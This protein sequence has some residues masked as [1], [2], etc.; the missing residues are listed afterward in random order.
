MTQTRGRR[1]K[2]EGG[3]HQVTKNGR[4]VW[5][6][7]VY[8]PDGSEKTATAIKKTDAA[9]LLK[10]LRNK[11]LSV[12]APTD[13]TVVSYLDWWLDQQW[14]KVG[15]GQLDE[16]TVSDYA[17]SLGY[18]KERFP[19]V[20]L[21]DLTSADVYELLRHLAKRG[22]TRKIKNGY[23]VE[24]L[25]RRT[26]TRVRSHLAMALRTARTLGKIPV[27]VA[28]DVEIPATVD[29]TPQR[30]LTPAQAKLLLEEAEG[31]DT[32]V[33]AFLLTGFAAGLRPGENLG[34]KWQYLDWDEATLEIEKTLQRKKRHVRDGEVIPERLVIGGVKRGINASRRIMVLPPQV[35][36][37]LR[38][39]QVEQK[40]QQLRAGARWK[41]RHGLIFTS[42]V[43]TPISS[44]NMARRINIITKRL[45]LG[46]WSLSELT[47]H[48]FA[49]HV[50]G[51]LQPQVMEKAMGH[52]VGSSERKQYIHRDKPVV[53]EHLEPMARILGE[54]LGN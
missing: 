18:V 39:W 53:T 41:N 35:L 8:L 50:E 51:E 16:G 46:H 7:T 1:A 29:P 12:E 49:T 45:N 15:T 4:L 11:W 47:R 54:I 44:N 6:A 10:E 21:I 31:T 36:Q 28:L 13:E 52:S 19:R 14:D 37:A 48:S 17:F 30:S 32:L 42:E 34:A 40:E 43:G 3:L 33:Y 23:V 20:R 38:R 26:V 27:N 5:K 2:G 24:P 22:R 9:N 25:S